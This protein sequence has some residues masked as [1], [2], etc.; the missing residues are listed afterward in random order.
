MVVVSYGYVAAGMRVEFYQ[1]EIQG[2]MAGN[3]IFPDSGKTVKQSLVS[4]SNSHEQCEFGQLC[5]LFVV[6][7]SNRMLLWDTYHIRMNRQGLPA[8]ISR[9]GLKCIGCVYYQYAC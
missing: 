2:R 8:I 6:T 4:I 9:L 5:S 3:Q 7:V 1:H